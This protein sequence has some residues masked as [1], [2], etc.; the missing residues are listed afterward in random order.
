[1]RR[2]WFGYGGNSGILFPE[3]QNVNHTGLQTQ[4]IIQV[5]RIY[6]N[7][8]VKNCFLEKNLNSLPNWSAV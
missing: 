5:S 8:H 3:Y 1:M 6:V 2:N 4:W 7:L